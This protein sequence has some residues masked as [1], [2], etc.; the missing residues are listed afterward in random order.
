MTVVERAARLSASTNADLLAAA[1]SLVP[2]LRARSAKSP[3]LD[4]LPDSTIADMEKARL[5]EMLV[6]K[7]YGGWELSLKEYMDIIVEI[8]RGDG[9]SAW[10][11]EII[12][13]NMWLAA[14]LYPKDVAVEIFASDNCRTCG[15]GTP[16]LLKAKRVNGGIFIEEGVWSFNSGVYHAG[17]SILGIT[18]FDQAGKV[19]DKGAAPVPVS[20]LTLLHDWDAIG[21]RA[22]GSTSV[23]VKDLFIPDERISLQSK[24]VRD[25]YRSAHLRD[26]PLYRIAYVPLFATTLVFPALGMAKAALEIF[27]ERT[28]SRNIAFTTYKQDEAAITHLQVG[29]SAAKIDAAELMLVRSVHE[30][31]KAA[32]DNVAL[33]REQRVRIVRD[34]GVASQ[35][36]WQAVDGL[37]TASGSSFAYSS[38][39]ISRLWRDVRV[40][41]LHGTIYPSFTMELGGRILSGKEPN[42]SMIV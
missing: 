2:I 14:T 24:A 8:A 38:N 26:R 30:I 13:K 31:E 12:A 39:P 28:H 21:L 22:S 41:G 5:F 15:A 11:L 10:V 37:A 33:S 40:A 25:I 36:I 1:R 34:A 16:R 4:R 42:T 27:L 32:A 18:I 3:E 17:W 9:A 29:D 19:V 20:Q 35:M 6:P 7:V 23:S